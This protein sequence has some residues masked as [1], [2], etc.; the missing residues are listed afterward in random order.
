MSDV[1]DPDDP[2]FDNDSPWP[3]RLLHVPTMTSHKWRPGNKYGGHKEP[4]YH[5]I[6]Y[7]WG[8]WVLRE[9]HTR[10]DIGSMVVMGVPWLI[11]RVNP[12]H[13]QAAEFDSAVHEASRIHVPSWETTSWWSRLKQRFKDSTCQ[14]L[15]LDVACIDQRGRPEG[16]AEIGRQA[17][18][19]RGAKHT[20][21]WLSWISYPDLL[22]ITQDLRKL[23]VAMLNRKHIDLKSY[24]DWLN[25]SLLR[26]QAL[27]S[28][29]WFSSLWTLQEAFLCPGAIILARDGQSVEL[30]MYPRPRDPVTLNYFTSWAESIDRAVD[31][32]HLNQ[33]SMSIDSQSS[34]TLKEVIETSG[35]A[36]LNRGN[37]MAT[38]TMATFRKASFKPDRVYGI[39]QIFG[40]HFKV[41]E[42]SEHPKPNH[43]YTVPE[44]QDELG[45]LL[46]R[47]LPFL[48]QMHTHQ[49]PPAFG[50]GWRITESSSIA[51]WADAQVKHL[52]I[53]SKGLRTGD[54]ITACKLTTT[55]IDGELWGS[56]AGKAC[57]FH[58]IEKAWRRQFFLPSNKDHHWNWFSPL[59]VALDRVAALRDLNMPLMG[60]GLQDIAEHPH[61]V[62]QSLSSYL[63]EMRVMVF[64]LSQRKWGD[65]KPKNWTEPTEDTFWGM[66]LLE[67]H[68]RNQKYWHR[69]GICRW[70]SYRLKSVSA[71]DPDKDILFGQ[72]S[73]WEHLSGVFG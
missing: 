49:R 28:D 61:R 15:W 27:V 3:R 23:A 45:S 62:A 12:D 43:E 26:F 25:T 66:I 11:P 1:P 50:K 8:R 65:A 37:A 44:L 47:Y 40:D 4:A 71:D 33:D 10:P 13:F 57:N 7:T 9:S 24:R 19:F 38:L 20:Y 63:K 31:S 16:K 29:P 18:I 69:L 42:A 60:T 41:G 58:I 59:E 17:R 39:M 53:D 52:D 68:H 14:F 73:Q 35:L 21:I 30:E 5:A 72:G 46:L 70:T 32:I 6:S 2:A 56:L 64:L 55:V 48:S 36:V 22:Q 54:M 51:L 34:R 67:Q